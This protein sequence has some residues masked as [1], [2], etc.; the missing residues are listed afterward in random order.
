MY[1]AMQSDLAAGGEKTMEH[2]RTILYI[3]DRSNRNNSVLAA[4]KETGCE[5]LSTDS[6]TQGVAF[7]Y[8][9]R[10]VSAVV[11]DSQVRK[12][13]NFDVVE[14]LRKIRPEVPVVLKCCDQIHSKL[15]LTET[16]VSTDKL[17]AVLQH[18]LND[19]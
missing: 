19:V 1:P 15:S 17:L 6:L 18:L 13:A 8:I 16:C 2:R 12:H 5:V 7:L 10:Q 14:S 9:L 4:I 11:L 3:F